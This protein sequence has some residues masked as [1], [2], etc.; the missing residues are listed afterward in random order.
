MVKN[1]SFSDATA[2][3]EGIQVKENQIMKNN[4]IITFSCRKNLAIEL[5]PATM[6][7]YVKRW[8]PTVYLAI[9]EIGP[10]LG[11]FEDILK[12]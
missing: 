12:K 1:G 4:S 2:P 5:L 9:G 6:Y 10:L 11:F 8:I 7:S 3:E